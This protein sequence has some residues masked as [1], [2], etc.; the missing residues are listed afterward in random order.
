MRRRDFMTLVGGAQGKDIPMSCSTTIFALF[1][2]AVIP[3]TAS[4]QTP[5][6]AA[7]EPDIACTQQG[8]VRGVVEGDML[9]FKGI[10]YARPPVGPL[11]WKPTEAA[12]SWSGVRDGSR[13]GAICPQIS[14]Q[15]VKGDEDC[16]TINVWRPRVRPSQALPVMV[17]LTGGGNHLFSGQGTSIFGGLTY[18]GEKLVPQGVVFVS[19]NLRLGVLGFLAHPALDAERPEK[20]SGNYGSLD[21][22]AM[23]RWLKAN[24]SAFGG[25]PNKIFLF[26]TSA[27]GGNICALMTSP[28]TR[29]LIHGVAM[30]SSV[31]MG[32]EF[33]ALDDARKGT[34]ARVAAATGC[35]TAADIAACL[36]DK[37]VIDIVSAVPGTFTVLARHYG[38]NVD[39]HIFPDQPLKLITEGRYPMMP[40]II[41]N[42]SQ[43]TLP[44]ANSAGQVTDEASYAAAIDS[45]FG[46]AQRERVL[47]NYPA[48]SYSTPRLAFAQLT[49]DSEFTCQSRRVARAFSKMQREPVYRYIFTQTQENDP[50]LKAGG[51]SHTIE[52]AFLF[53]GRYQPTEAEGAIQRQMVGYWTRMVRTGNPNGGNDPQWP[54][55]TV[56]NDAYLE[57]GATTVAKQG[58]ADAKCDFWDTVTFPWPH[59]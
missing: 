51:A 10:P 9:A 31:P 55:S 8:A 41:G 46:P 32:C 2:L 57:I 16:L 28:L 59:L 12:E 33:Q 15:E 44:W 23:L 47:A 34:G 7:N 27:G 49:T 24:I 50:S 21:Q 19:Y 29:G 58:P 17:W 6:C 42:T 48:K 43:E 11:R 56:E 22:I 38:P 53:P 40:V 35:N 14:G 45:V 26:G 37:S 20:I 18:S 54:A 36:R 3:A 30:Q 4:A 13:F 52:H 39:G 1:L 25:D 5:S